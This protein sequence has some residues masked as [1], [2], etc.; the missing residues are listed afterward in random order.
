[1]FIGYCYFV[2]VL[3]VVIVYNLNVTRFFFSVHKYNKY[4]C[5]NVLNF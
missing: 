3:C 2:D 5:K 4:M 1:M